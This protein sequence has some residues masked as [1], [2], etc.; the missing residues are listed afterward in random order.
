MIDL[1]ARLEGIAAGLKHAPDRVLRVTRNPRIPHPLRHRYALL[2]AQISPAEHADF[3]A[4]LMFGG[5]APEPNG[6]VLP[7][8]LSYLDE[9][10]IIRLKASAGRIRAL[11]RASSRHNFFLLTERCNHYCLMCSQPP[12]NV[13][14]D[15]L[16][17]ELLDVIPLIDRDA[18]FIGITGGE[19]TLLGSRFLRVVEQLKLYL[20]DTVVHILS[21]GRAFADASFCD[22]YAAI[23]HPL[24]TVGIPL[25]SDVSSIHDYVVQADGAFDQTLRGI[26]S[27]KQ[28]GQRVE[29]RVVIHRQTYERLPKL[30][31]FICRNLTFVDHVALMGLELTG[32]TKANLESLWIDPFDYRAELTEA[33]KYLECAGINVSVYNHQLCTIDR[34]IWHRAASS[35]SDWKNEYETICRS[36]L[37]RE[38]CGG[39]F[40]TSR[41]RRSRHIAAVTEPLVQ[42]IQ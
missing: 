39:F 10:D 36:C 9:K 20:P 12:K 28:R 21:N 13:K 8:V 40:T 2:Q 19:P 15:W 4:I 42:V 33:T 41:L 17:D 1:N 29:I 23:A 7:Q 26:L 37:V 14:D 38:R 25:Y 31:E 27:L 5:I 32:F 30:A 11:Y 24:V 16:V 3:G 34:S 35:I 18:K 6:V 22:A